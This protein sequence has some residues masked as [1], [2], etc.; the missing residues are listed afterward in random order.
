MPY[1]K[2]KKKIIDCPA[3]IIFFHG[4]WNRLPSL[5]G[6]RAGELVRLRYQL[7]A[8]VIFFVCFDFKKNCPVLRPVRYGYYARLYFLIF[9]M[10]MGRLISSILE[11][12]VRF[13]LVSF[14]AFSISLLSR[15]LDAFFMERAS[16]G[17]VVWKVF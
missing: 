4:P 16:I 10:S 14:S 6:K 5:R 9:E 15:C 7:Y 2:I 17:P 3:K 8:R 1:L 13:P 12:C 11:A